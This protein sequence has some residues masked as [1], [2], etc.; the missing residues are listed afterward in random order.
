[1]LLP[2]SAHSP[3][4][5]VKPREYSPPAPPV[6]WQELQQTAGSCTTTPRQPVPGSPPPLPQSPSLY[7]L[8][9]ANFP[10]HSSLFQ[11]AARFRTS[12]RAT[13]QR[14]LVR[15]EP[16]AAPLIPPIAVVPSG[17]WFLPLDEFWCR[18]RR[19]SIACQRL[20]PGR[21]LQFLR[22]QRLQSGDCCQ[23]RVFQRFIQRRQF[24]RKWG[25]A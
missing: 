23:Q 25:G 15:P 8:S 10:R 13:P 12:E 5:F 2:Y 4:N 16:Q 19:G 1:M 17:A 18:R 7:R 9:S 6:P 3:A 14:A 11:T 21:N 22:L 24:R 20:E